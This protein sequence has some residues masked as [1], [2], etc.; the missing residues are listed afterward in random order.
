MSFSTPS[1]RSPWSVLPALCSGHPS[2]VRPLGL[3]PLPPQGASS[4]FSLVGVNRP[5]L[6]LD[7]SLDLERWPNM[8]F[9]LLARVSRPLPLTA[10]ARP[11]PQRP[12]LTAG[13]AV[14]GHTGGG[15]RAQPHSD[16]HLGTGGAAR[17]PAAP[18]VPALQLLGWFCLHPCPVPWGCAHR[19]QTGTEDLKEQG[20][21]G[22]GP[23]RGAGVVVIFKEK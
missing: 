13:R 1:K 8:T 19:P 18:L 17:R 2:P 11:R 5:A 21:R 15:H 20:G 23:A 9:R 12:G 3:S 16:S 7:Q 6:R 22:V 4:F 14:A 10:R